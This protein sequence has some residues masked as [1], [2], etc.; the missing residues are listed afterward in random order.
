MP[1]VFIVNPIKDR[2]GTRAMATRKRRTAKTRRVARR[3][4]LVDDRGARKGLAALPK[5]RRRNP[6][7]RHRRR[8]HARRFRNPIGGRTRA[9]GGFW[10]PV[11][12]GSIAF[13]VAAL[14]TDVAYGYMPIPSSMQ[15][16]IMRPI[17]KL[18]VAAAIGLAAKYT[19]P[20]GVAVMAAAGAIGG[21]I[22]DSAKT[23]MASAFPTLPLSGMG[24]GMS[25]SEV[26]PLALPAATPNYL[27]AGTTPDYLG[28][29]LDGVGEGVGDYLT[30]E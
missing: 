18:A 23:Y 10:G 14:V 1:S 19:M 7:S 27:G 29:Y 5:R 2:R 17:G 8:H 11:L 30:N 22:Y 28:A 3:N 15:T 25:F 16:G 4:P 6:I 12:T 13:P 20:R 24:D 9:A 21:V 26:P